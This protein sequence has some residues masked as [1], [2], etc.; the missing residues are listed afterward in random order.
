MKNPFVRFREFVQGITTV[1][2]GSCGGDPIAW[3]KDLMLRR[4]EN[5]W[6]DGQETDHTDWDTGGSE[7][8]ANRDSMRTRATNER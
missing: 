7:L 6:N 5:G 3:E 2:Y 8:D 4:R 1:S